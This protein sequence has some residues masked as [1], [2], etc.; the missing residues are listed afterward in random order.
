MKTAVRRWGNS[1][2]LR[3]PSAF[4]TKTQ[5]SE[6]SKVEVTLR[7]GTIVVRPMV[8]KHYALKDLLKRVTP[9][10]LHNSISTGRAAGQEVW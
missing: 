8:R 5:I 2:A 9:A 1:L 7:S 10:N 6:G 3:I 4:V